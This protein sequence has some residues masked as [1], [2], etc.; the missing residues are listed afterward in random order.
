MHYFVKLLIKIKEVRKLIE[1]GHFGL[2]FHS[3]EKQTIA[4]VLEPLHYIDKEMW[5]L[6]CA[7]SIMMNH[8]YHDGN[9]RTAYLLIVTTYDIDLDL[10]GALIN[11]TVVNNLSREY[12]MKEV[13]RYVRGRDDIEFYSF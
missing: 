11:N 5:I 2:L 9:K 13:L 7:Y 12:F 6:S 10:L 3:G 1:S 8:I 4:N